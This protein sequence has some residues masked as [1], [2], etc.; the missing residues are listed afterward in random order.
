MSTKEERAKYMREWLNA[1]EER[2]IKNR[3]RSKQWVEANKDRAKLNKRK[4]DLKSRYNMTIDEWENMLAK[5]GNRC[6]I[7]HTTDYG[8]QWHTDH[9]H[10]T[11]KVRGILC[12]TC[13]SLLGMAKDSV[14]T[15]Y[16]AI[17][18]LEK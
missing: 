12:G 3:E 5:Q 8:K 14:T 7:C 10:N 4:R 18:Y 13:N 2:K 1:S 16:N 15:L 17:Q 11:G 6:A 9:C